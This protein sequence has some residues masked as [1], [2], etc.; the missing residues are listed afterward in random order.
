MLAAL[1][2]A[3]VLAAAPAPA[4]QERPLT[5]AGGDGRPLAASVF[6]PP[7]PGPYPA[8]VLVSGFGPQDRYGR[9]DGGDGPYGV[10]ARELAGRGVAVLAYD[11][12]GIAGSAGAP[13]AWLDRRPLAADAAAAVR[14]LAA[15]PGVDRARVAIVGHSQGGALAMEAA[16]SGPATRVVTLA[17]PG[18][19]LGQLRRAAGAPGRLLQRLAGAAVANAT[20]RHDPLRDA[21][22]ARLPL[23]AVHGTRDRTVP[24][25]EMG[26]IADARRAAGLPTRT[27]RVPGAGHFLQV[28]GRVPAPALDA[29]A[30][31][32]A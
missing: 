19:P 8:A 24:V 22:R 10:L 23:L 21:V 5:L 16:A 11:K 9:L 2:S 32:I 13:L 17:S 6:V 28:D 7:G 29:V 26:R 1:L 3:L 12:R 14:A 31:F 20:L 4:V 25:A 15:L 27:L 30:R 18:R